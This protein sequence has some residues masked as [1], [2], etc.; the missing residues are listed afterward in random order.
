MIN[1]LRNEKGLTLVELLATL[2]IGAIVLSLIMGIHVTIQ[3]QYTKQKADI[4]YFLDVT[5]AAKAITKDIRMADTV[6]VIDVDEIK[7]TWEDDT[8]TEVVREYQLDNNIVNRDGGGYISEVDMLKFEK[9][10]VNTDITKIKFTVKGE[11]EKEI[12]TE[13]ILR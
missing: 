5:T 3:K 7:L 6:E 12:Q 8:G 9:V 13:I 4:G 10:D 1:K 2:V 11:S